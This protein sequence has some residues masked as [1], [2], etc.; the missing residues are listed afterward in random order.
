MIRAT[1][2]YMKRLLLIGLMLFMVPSAG[3][4][5]IQPDPA[6]LIIEETG[7]LLLIV[8][9]PAGEI[10]TADSPW[11]RIGGGESYVLPSG[12]IAVV[13]LKVTVPPEQRVGE[14][15]L[16][17]Y[18][19][20]E[21]ISTLTVRVTLSSEEISSLQLLADVGSQITAMGDE[22]DSSLEGLTG[23][24]EDLALKQE[25]L[26]A[27]EEENR[28]LR[29]ETTLLQDQITITETQNHELEVSG[30]LLRAESPILFVVGLLIGAAGVFLFYRKL[31]KYL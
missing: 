3:A 6:L 18:A 25:R 24:F 22:F 7:Q 15:I 29:A 13:E 11:V 9:S 14:Y 30:N 2:K 20:G 21:Q 10:L 4:L 28:N 5:S 16:G 8:T 31:H 12:G 23:S 26:G 19:N 27:L 1:I 17:V